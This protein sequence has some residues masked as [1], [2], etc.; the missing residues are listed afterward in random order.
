MPAGLV[1]RDLSWC[2]SASVHI[3]LVPSIPTP[4]L[5]FFVDVSIDVRYVSSMIL[6]AQNSLYWYIDVNELW[7]AWYFNCYEILTNSV[8]FGCMAII[9]AKIPHLDLHGLSIILIYNCY[10]YML[11]CI[12]NSGSLSL[13]YVFIS[14]FCPLVGYFFPTGCLQLWCVTSSSACTMWNFPSRYYG[15][16]DVWT[17]GVIN[18]IYITICIW[19]S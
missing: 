6:A 19:L 8:A 12:D 16:R 13:W 18:L 3:H 4:T 10:Y 7:W 2:F 17:F 5:S 9:N 11:H 1:C 15:Q 14:R